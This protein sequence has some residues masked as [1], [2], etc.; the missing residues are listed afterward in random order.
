MQLRK[1]KGVT[2]RLSVEGYK[3]ILLKQSI[4]LSGLAVISGS[5]STGKSSFMQPFLILKQ[6]LENN[7]DGSSLVINGENTNL[8]ESDQILNKN[9]TDQSFSVSVESEDNK[10]PESATST[11]TYDSKDGFLASSS[12]L[13]KDGRIVT[14]KRKMTQS[15]MLKESKKI[16]NG[17]ELSHLSI[18]KKMSI[19]EENFAW[20]VGKGKPFLTLE[21]SPKTTKENKISFSIGFNPSEKIE[22]FVQN[23][24][25]VPGI[26]SNPERQ[27]KIER[28]TT[29]YQ[30]RFD[31]Y[32]ASIIYNW[33]VKNDKK[34]EKLKEILVYL[35]LA[36]N[37]EAKKINEA[38]ISIDISRTMN[39]KNDDMV[40]L[41]DVGFGISQV[42]PAIVA[43]IEASK[44][45][46]VFIEQ[47]EIHLH[48]K[49][50]FKLAKVICNFVKE[51]KKVI[52]ET[53]SSIFIRGLQIEVAEGKLSPNLFSLNWFSQDDHGHTHISES[54]LDKNGAF[55]DWPA[56]FD[57]TYLY[58]E[59][60]YLNAVEKNMMAELNDST[61]GVK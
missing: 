54:F 25:H 15:E 10:N 43:L 55:G 44:R 53:H 14:V 18:F 16:N 22:D 20:K 34:L 35:G 58:V 39:S 38:H 36:S 1:S 47:P 5:N 56:D 51:N 40:N 28:Y 33:C 3:S 31:K 49:A 11:F 8:T 26:R 13:N 29:K 41:S 4:S 52:V 30:G 23:I 32:V 50:Q 57:D 12:A 59:D 46:T 7:T 61:G 21:L 42:L 17:G 45:N 2:M 60:R 48:P 24:I 37:I 27:Y 9:K 19:A 6:T